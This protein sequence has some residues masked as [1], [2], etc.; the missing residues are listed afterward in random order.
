[1]SLTLSMISQGLGSR[2]EC[3][4]NDIAAWCPDDIDIAARSPNNIDTA[5]RK[6]A[7]SDIVNNEFNNS[8]ISRSHQRY[9]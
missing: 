8:K 9:R 6:H 2:T 3:T 4:D 1:M 7:K 5:A